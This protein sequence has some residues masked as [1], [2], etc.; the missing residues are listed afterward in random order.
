MKKDNIFWV[1]YSDLLTSLFF[2]ML[3]LFGITFVILRQKNEDLKDSADRLERIKEIEEALESLNEEYFAFDAEN[4]RY[5]LNIDVLFPPNSDDF[6]RLT[7]KA[8]EDLKS[9]GWDLYNKIRDLVNK[10]PDV[11][12]LL[13]VEGNAARSNNNWL[14]IPDEG[15]KLSFR[16]ALSLVN[17]WKEDCKIPFNEIQSNCELLIAGSGHFGQSRERDEQKNKRFTIQITSKVG[18]L[19][20]ES[21]DY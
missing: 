16:R 9:A 5:K 19:L 4:K 18:K 6:S 21:N 13:V 12:Y 1:G 3:I 10:N 14:R 11:A 17:Y 8:R 20:S 7:L 15:Y 2:V